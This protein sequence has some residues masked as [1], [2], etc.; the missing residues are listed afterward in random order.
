MRQ[1]APTEDGDKRRKYCTSTVWP[2]LGARAAKRPERNGTK[3]NNYLCPSCRRSR[4]Q[5]RTRCRGTLSWRTCGCTGQ[6]SRGRNRA[7]CDTPTDF[8]RASSSCPPPPAPTCTA[9][10]SSRCRQKLCDR[11][12]HWL[13]WV[14]YSSTCN[15]LALVGAVSA[16]T[17]LVGRQEGHT[18]CKKLSGGVLAW[19][20]VWSEVQTC[21]WPS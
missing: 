4:R 18:A 9:R 13:V 7:T 8:R 15:G 20:S 17:L 10:S 16:L 2:A 14:A 6:R 19:L 11:D 5:R 21:I 3:R 1:L 12:G